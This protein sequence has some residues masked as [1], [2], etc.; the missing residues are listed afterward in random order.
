MATKSNPNDIF[1]FNVAVSYVV[2]DFGLVRANINR[3]KQELEASKN[4]TEAIKSQLAYQVANLYYGIIYTKNAI[5]I[6]ESVL[7]FLTDNLKDI[8]TRVKFGD[9]LQYD[10]L[11]IQS[12]IDQEL[13]RKVDLENNLHKQLNLLDYITGVSVNNGKEFDFVI[14]DDELETMTNE[15]KKHN[16]DFII[17]N[18]RIKLAEADRIIASKVSRPTLSLSAGSGY[19]NGFT[20][21]INNLKFTAI[22]GVNLSVPIYNGGR[23]EKQIKLNDNAVELQKISLKALEN[24][25]NKD[26]KQALLDS[27]TAKERLQNTEG[28]IR[29]SQ[30]AVAL[31]QTR[32]KGSVGTNLELTN[33]SANLQKAE[34]FKMRID[35]Q[36]VRRCAI[37]YG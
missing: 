14:I 5:T 13:N 18:D 28:Q 29:Q 26:F 37:A 22:V 6:Q 25:I 12:F 9:A 20:P 32:F 36:P 24:T 2:F 27:S 31:A 35:L 8:N 3:S 7:K 34:L 19:R 30:A 21:E 17:Q 33:A 23:I 16:S 1:N 10:A 15:A 4:N 11:T